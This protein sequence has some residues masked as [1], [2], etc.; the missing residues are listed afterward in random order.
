MFFP[1]FVAQLAFAQYNVEVTVANVSVNFC[2]NG[3]RILFVDFHNLLNGI[4]NF[5]YGNNDVV[6]QGN[7]ADKAYGFLAVTTHAPDAVVCFQNVYCASFFAQIVELFHFQIQLVFVV[8][9]YGNDYIN[10]I[11]V[12]RSCL[13]IQ[14]ICGATHVGIVHVFDTGRIHASFDKLGNN[15]N[16]ILRFVEHSKH[17]K[18]IRSH[19]QQLQGCFGNNTQSS[20]ATHY[21]LFHAV[22]SGTFFQT[23]ANFYDF[24]SGSNHF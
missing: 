1:I 6:G 2:R 5:I 10:T 11:F 19:G 22:A 17:I 7:K 12:V 3:E 14:I 24:A 18:F 4:S 8:G 9:F 16:C 23:G 20:F 13:E 21:Q 15:V